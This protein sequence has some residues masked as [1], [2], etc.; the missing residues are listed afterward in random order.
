[1]SRKALSNAF[2]SA[3]RETLVILLA[4]LVICAWVIG[5][6]GWNA[7]PPTDGSAPSTETIFGF[8]AWI[9]W[10]IALPWIVAN[11]FT[12]WFSLAYMRDDDRSAGGQDG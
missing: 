4:W 10:G 7:Y 1:M 11:A 3:R 2:R 9:I 5:Y 12:I 6:C 8:P